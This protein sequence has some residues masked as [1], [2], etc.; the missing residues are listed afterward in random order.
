MILRL[1]KFD[2]YDK[3]PNLKPFDIIKEREYTQGNLNLY[4]SPLVYQALHEKPNNFVKY[5]QKLLLN[6]L[7]L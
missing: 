5:Y 4:F 6:I 2:K 7:L 1:Q 3:P